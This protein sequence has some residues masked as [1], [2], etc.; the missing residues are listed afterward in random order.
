MLIK[1]TIF[2]NYRHFH[3]SLIL[4]SFF[5]PRCYTTYNHLLSLSPPP[6]ET[7]HH[8]SP[9]PSF[10]I[11]TTPLEEM[12]HQPHL[13]ES[14]SIVLPLSLNAIILHLSSAK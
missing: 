14:I 2:L 3:S 8:H 10:S 13:P 4:N 6:P 1:N 9:P 7:P 12:T 5:L 11:Y